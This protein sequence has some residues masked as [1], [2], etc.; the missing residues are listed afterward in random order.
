MSAT[1]R[2]RRLPTVVPAAPWRHVPALLAAAGLLAVAAVAAMLH[3]HALGAPLWID[4]GISIGIAS[5]PL[6]DIPSVLREDGSPPLYYLLLHV[7]MSAFGSSETAT[8]ALSLTFLALAVPAAVWAAWTPFGAPAGA[9]AGALIGLNPYAAQYA[10]ETRMYS[11]VLLLA[12]LATGAFVRAFV[13]RRRRH[14]ALFGV[15][16]AALLYTHNWA[17]FYAA[18]AGLAYLGLLAAGPDRRTLLRDGALAFGAAALLF[19]PWLPTL[20]YQAAHTGAPWSHVPSPRSLTHALTRMW[21]G[22]VP[23][24]L[25]LLVAGGGAF[26]LLRRGSA[27]QRRAT[28]AVL[29]TAALTLLLAYAWSHASSPA[30][31]LRYLVIVVAPLAVF[32]GAGLGRTGV[33]GIATVAVVLVFSWHGHPSI[34]ALSHKSNVRH[35]ARTLAHDL[36]PG[37]TVISMQPEQVP[38][39]R[40]YLGPRLRYV[41]PLG[42]ATDPRVAD[43]RDA[44]HRLQRARF[45]TVIAPL[46]RTLRPGARVLLVRPLF[47]RG[48]SAWSRAITRESD[49]WAAALR[50]RL[51]VVRTVRPSRG[52]SRSTVAGQLLQRG[53]S[54]P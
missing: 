12:V 38:A 41:S 9:I 34:A 48:S 1:T 19:A 49:A 5:H 26:E 15:L 37:S 46:L 7:W 11:L 8:H 27:Q 40:Y 14:V 35:V 4:E 45:A 18:A 28:L 20:A 54:G 16:L 33:L 53:R 23:E 6:A 21:S 22:V 32:A 39:L 51:H 44:L 3:A 52:S 50:R 30:W 47:A 29:A 43:W 10:D 36:P 31:A 17:L 25:V 2:I 24:T 13:L 42:V